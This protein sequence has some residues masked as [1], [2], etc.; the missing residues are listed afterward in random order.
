MNLGLTDDE[1]AAFL[2]ELN[3]LI[4]GDR[5]FLSPRIKTLKAIRAKLR[6]EPVREPLP[7]PPRSMRHREQLRGRNGEQSA[8][9]DV[10]TVNKASPTTVIREIDI[11][12]VGM[13]LAGGGPDAPSN[14]QWANQGG[15]EG[16]GSVVRSLLNYGRHEAPAAS[17]FSLLGSGC[18]A[19]LRVVYDPPA[20]A[21]PGCCTTA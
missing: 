6:P 8:D 14:I 13:P 5:Y 17:A 12:R 15:R 18:G 11:W 1:A 4:D 10:F 3:G 19:G 7:P 21:L 9:C 2:R 16:E 20:V